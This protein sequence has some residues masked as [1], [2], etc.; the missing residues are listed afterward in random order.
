M[1]VTEEMV[2]GMTQTEF[3]KKVMSFV[4]KLPLMY[5]KD[6]RESLSAIKAN[7]YST[8]EELKRSMKHV[9]KDMRKERER[10]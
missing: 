1:E 3:R 2:E 4:R 8:D 7:L 9:F 5:Q 6:V 10:S